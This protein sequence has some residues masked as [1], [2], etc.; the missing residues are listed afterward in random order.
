MRHR[1][2]AAVL[3]LLCAAGCRSHTAAPAPTG[4]TGSAAAPP[5]TPAV[6]GFHPRFDGLYGSA[7]SD[8]ERTY[9]RFFPNGTVYEVGTIVSA[10][11]DDV[12]RW[13]RPGDP[14]VVDNGPWK[15]GPDGS[16]TSRSDNGTV[17]FTVLNFHDDGFDLHSVSHINGHVGTRHLVFSP[18]S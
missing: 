4:R 6:A 9:V 12:R 8:T 3:V 5:K 2:F 1:V 13:L 15:Y 7:P 18:D 14:H 10:S 17:D 16:F 11:P